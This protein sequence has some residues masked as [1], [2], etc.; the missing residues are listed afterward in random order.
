MVTR[1]GA[2]CKA[3]EV[4]SAWDLAGGAMAENIPGDLRLALAGPTVWIDEP[5]LFDD[6]EGLLTVIQNLRTRREVFISGLSQTSEG[7]PFGKAMPYLLA[8][9]DEVVMLRARCERCGKL[10]SATRTLWVGT[11]EKGGQV[12]P[13]DEGY[14]V[15]CPPCGAEMV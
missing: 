11:E 2:S 3:V 7:E 4:R 6:E 8:V 12:R 13:G 1:S 15:V 10:R 5:A 9:A 14:V